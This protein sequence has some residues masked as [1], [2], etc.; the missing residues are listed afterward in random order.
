[1]NVVPPKI[2]FTVNAS[3]HTRQLFS[4]LMTDFGCSFNPLVRPGRA[5]EMAFL[6]DNIAPTVPCCSYYFICVC[7]YGHPL[8]VDVHF[9]TTSTFS[10]PTSPLIARLK[11]NRGITCLNGSNSTRQK[12]EGSTSSANGEYCI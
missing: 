1:M 2:F 3:I 8:D 5:H 4:A 6:D 12:A 10:Q 7:V 11:W 9:R